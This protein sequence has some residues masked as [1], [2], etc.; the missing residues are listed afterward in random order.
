VGK[1]VGIEQEREHGQMS[2][3]FAAQ[4]RSF[5]AT[6]GAVVTGRAWAKAE[7]AKTTSR[8]SRRRAS[9]P[10]KP[11]VLVVGGGPAGIGAALGAAR[12]GCKTLP[13]ENHAFFGGVAS[14]C[15]G[16]PINQMRPGGKPRSHVHELIIQKLLQYGDQAV[17]IGNS[18]GRLGGQKHGELCRHGTRRRNRGG[19]R[20]QKEVYAP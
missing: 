10:Y 11:D 18:R 2:N 12:A 3:R 13:V 8:V 5:L 6:V 1:P 7:G 20:S 4:R 19:D 16:M 14:W 17:R 15:L 9:I